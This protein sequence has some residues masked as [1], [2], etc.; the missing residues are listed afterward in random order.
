MTNAGQS[1]SD[2][3]REALYAADKDQARNTTAIAEGIGYP[4]ST[5]RRTLEDLTAHGVTERQSQGLG[6]ADLWQ[7]SDWARLRYEG[8][9]LPE[10]SVGEY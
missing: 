3:M 2:E 9:T 1:L 8:L 4:T 6:K 5:V 10:K 7:L